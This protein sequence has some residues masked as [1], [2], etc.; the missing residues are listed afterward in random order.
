MQ[1]INKILVLANQNRDGLFQLPI[2]N[3]HV[4]V[5]FNQDGDFQLREVSCTTNRGLDF[6][7]REVG[8]RYLNL[9]SDSISRFLVTP[10]MEVER[11]FNTIRFRYLKAVRLSSFT[12]PKKYL[13]YRFNKAFQALAGLKVYQGNASVRKDND[14]FW[15][16][17]G[18]T[19]DARE[20]NWQKDRDELE[21]V[22]KL[23]KVVTPKPV[24]RAYAELLAIKPGFHELF[25]HGD[26]FDAHTIPTG[27]SPRDQV[28]R[29]L[30]NKVE[31]SS[32]TLDEFPKEINKR[33]YFGYAPCNV[34]EGPF[35]FRKSLDVSYFDEIRR[36]RTKRQIRTLKDKFHIL[37][38]YRHDLSTQDKLERFLELAEPFCRYPAVTP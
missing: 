1:F 6:T 8:H 10:E 13:H 30:R 27:T 36:I 4:V 19:A 33:A 18:F 32:L 38:Y 3:S 37:D 35:V 24:T 12:N 5:V 2:S 11:I 21:S 23:L 26:Y 29:M 34:T 17:A 7:L 25:L 22:L 16:E 20:Q 31:L 9:D 28:F 14:T 15:Q